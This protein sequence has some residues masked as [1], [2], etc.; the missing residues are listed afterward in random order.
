MSS[1]ICFK[2]DQSK[3]LSS[4]NGLN[5]SF[6][7][8]V[9]VFT[10]LQYKSLKTLGKEEIAY[11]EQFLLFPQYFLPYRE[12]SATFIKSEIVV[13]KIFQYGRV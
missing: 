13:C 2:L 9:L 10:C 8:Q 1:A 3:I 11:N 4:G 7:K 5:P 12:L 6:P